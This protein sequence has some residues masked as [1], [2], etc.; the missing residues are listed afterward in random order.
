MKD[1]IIDILIATLKYW[2]SM[3]RLIHDFFTSIYNFV[4][5]LFGFNRRFYKYDEEMPA[6]K[7]KGSSRMGINELN[8]KIELLNS[9]ILHFK[10][11]S[12]RNFGRYKRVKV[13]NK[14]LAD[15]IKSLTEEV[16]KL[17]KDSLNNAKTS[18]SFKTPKRSDKEVLRLADNYSQEEL[19]NVYRRL[20]M[21]YHPDTHS[22][23]SRA[24]ILESTEEFV[25]ITKAYENLKDGN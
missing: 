23:M 7:D 1:K 24:Y 17:K 15:D 25:R 13:D 14:K 2:Q 3:I 8:E 9:Q 20:R 19:V 4:S 18:R 11:Q 5:K 16:D 22:H 21:K 12:D 10:G 6:K